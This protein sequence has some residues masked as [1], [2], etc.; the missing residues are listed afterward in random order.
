MT[1]KSLEEYNAERRAEI[2]R[3]SDSRTKPSGVA[4]PKCGE[5][6]IVDMSMLYTSSPPQRMV[7]CMACKHQSYIVA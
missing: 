2:E 7:V 1:L 3:R 6:M 4:C 5:E